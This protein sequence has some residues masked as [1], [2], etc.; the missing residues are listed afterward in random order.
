M[1]ILQANKSTGPGKP[2][3]CSSANTC[4]SGKTIELDNFQ[5]LSYRSDLQSN[6]C[7]LPH[8]ND[9]ESFREKALM[10]V[11]TLEEMKEQLEKI[12]NLIRKYI[13]EVRR[14]QIPYVLLESGY[15]VTL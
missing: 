15:F 10:G 6:R 1:L 7:N 2:C 3:P 8:V 4:N 5:S 9:V 11:A 14:R 12:E 13:D